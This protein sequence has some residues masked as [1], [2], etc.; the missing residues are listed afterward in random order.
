MENNKGQSVSTS[1]IYK[2]LERY[3]VLLFQ[4]IVQI[5]VARILSPSDY[6]IVAMMLVF[7]SIASVFINNGFN[8]AIIQKKEADDRD[9]GT[10]LLI[11]FLIGIIF[12]VI[13]FLAAPSIAHFYNE[14]NLVVCL[15]VLALILPIGSISSIQSAVAVRMMMFRKLFICN[16]ISSV[17]SG[18][19]GVV[20][21]LLGAG[22]WALIAQQISSVIVVAIALT[23]HASWK[24][25][26]AFD[27]NSAKDQF[28]FGW[29]MLSAA[30]IN[31]VYREL[32]SLIIGRKYSAT[33]LSFYTKGRTF[34]STITSGVDSAL[35]TVLLSSFSKKQD[36]IKEI[37]RM[38]HVSSSVNSYLLTPMLCFL[39][40][41]G[42]SLTS[43]LL[44][45]KWLPMVPYMQI[46][47][48]TFALHPMSSINL[49]ALAAI[50][51]SDVR[52]KL[53][54]IKKPFG[55]L[56]LI[57]SIPHGPLAIA[58][59]AAIT[60]IFSLFVGFMAC[61]I[62]LNYRISDSLR[63]ILPSFGISIGVGAIVYLLNSININQVLLLTIQF[64]VMVG[65]YIAF[66]AIF[67][68]FGYNFLKQKY[69]QYNNELHIIK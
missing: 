23:I 66:S 1:M 58:I 34:P 62:L 43:L 36:N 3:S 45:D 11:N 54:F 35:Q 16:I 32:N 18:A 26:F 4:T 9:F 65:L 50:G 60:S 7:I 17:I 39:A 56:L 21:A 67:N 48:V 51:R 10:A 55:I 6:G 52:L 8:S 38:M 29:K 30:L 64:I 57:L 28:R 14:P 41:V 25:R 31:A 22:Y 2:S 37:H 12:Y 46:C 47:C 42:S 49:Q 59:S 27:V 63:D 44:T 68:V 69:R 19:V 24:P 33:D 5:V 15:R 61:K 20:M 53:E 13:L 40:V